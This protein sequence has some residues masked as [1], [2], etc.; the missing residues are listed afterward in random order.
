MPKFPGYKRERPKR[1]LKDFARHVSAIDINS[2]DFN[3]VI[4]ACFEGIARKWWELISLKHE[5]ESCFKE[6]FIKKYWN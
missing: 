4:F 5:T 6:K 2:S 3:H 1:F